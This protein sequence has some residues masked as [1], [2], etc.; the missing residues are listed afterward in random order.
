MEL[1]ARGIPIVGIDWRDTREDALSML[2]QNGNPFIAVGF[3]PDSDAVMD[4]GVYGA[5]ET[6]L[7]DAE[8]II[9]V[10]HKAALNER[11]WQEKFARW[12]EEK[13]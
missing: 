12:F 5:P 11:V 3:D 10:K 2:R 6:F 8:G 4:W 13:R 9:R 1:K 7:I